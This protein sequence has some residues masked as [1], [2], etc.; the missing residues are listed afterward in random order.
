MLFCFKLSEICF[1]HVT[2][3]YDQTQTLINLTMPE[4]RRRNNTLE[5]FQNNNNENRMFTSITTNY[6]NQAGLILNLMYRS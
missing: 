6:R 1:C 4:Y 5:I 3:E 2:D